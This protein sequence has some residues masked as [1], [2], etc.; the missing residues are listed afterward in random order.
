MCHFTSVTA[1]ATK[2]FSNLSTA[3]LVLMITFLSRCETAA[4]F[5]VFG[6]FSMLGTYSQLVWLIRLCLGRLILSYVLTYFCAGASA[7]CAISLA[8]LRSDKKR[9][10]ESCTAVLAL[11]DFINWSTD[12]SSVQ[13]IRLV[14]PEGRFLVLRNTDVRG[15]RMVVA[16]SWWM[17]AIDFVWWSVLAFVN[18]CGHFVSTM[19]P[20]ALIHRLA[21]ISL[22]VVSFYSDTAVSNGF[23]FSHFTW[24]CPK[25][26][27]WL[28]MLMVI[29]V[30]WR[31]FVS[32]SDR[33]HAVSLRNG[34]Q[35]R[36][37]RLG[38]KLPIVC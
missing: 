7:V 20:C 2:W 6:I 23:C 17:Y 26:S 18:D 13:L 33:I 37:F 29:I 38:N 32:T 3:V 1:Q 30:Y 25:N 24:I 11:I 28:V 9:I 36:M 35:V 4:A 14:F 12:L 8:R 16:I 27:R 34:K 10:V 15:H 22:L 5:V 19:N 31:C 21:M